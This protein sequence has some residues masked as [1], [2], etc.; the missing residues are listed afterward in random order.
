MQSESTH[1]TTTPNK[2]DESNASDT[3]IR[4]TTETPERDEEKRKLVNLYENR[5]EE[6]HR[7]HV[8]ELQD[9]KQKHNDKV[10]SQKK[11]I[12]TYILNIYH[13]QSILI[14]KDGLKKY[15]S[16]RIIN[17]KKDK[18]IFT[19]KILF[20]LKIFSLFFKVNSDYN[21]RFLID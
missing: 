8:D 20:L 19:Y 15:D 7:R 17:Q 1:I 16:L 5:I 13:V 10:I 2:V 4:S 6:M 11:Y 21:C 9:L 3:F 14:R 18:K 12:Y